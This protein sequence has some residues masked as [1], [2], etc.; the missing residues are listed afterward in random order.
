MH[1]PKLRPVPNIAVVPGTGRGLCGLG[2]PLKGDEDRFIY[3]GLEGSCEID[4]GLLLITRPPGDNK[5]VDVM[6]PVILAVLGDDGWGPIDETLLRC[7]TAF[8]S[9]RAAP[10]AATASSD[11]GDR[12]RSPSESRRNLVF[13]SCHTRAGTLVPRADPPLPN[14]DP[15]EDTL[16]VSDILSNGTIQES[17][18]PVDETPRD[19]RNNKLLLLDISSPAVG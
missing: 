17:R 4:P 15:P 11:L 9:P 5:H 6:I 8:D 18:V 1:P 13:M 10:A 16:S 2:N 19:D 7:C 12:I 14:P 3:W